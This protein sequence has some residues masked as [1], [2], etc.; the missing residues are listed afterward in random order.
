MKRF[1]GPPTGCRD[2]VALGY[3]LNGYYL[4][5]GVKKNNSNKTEMQTVYCQFKQ[6]QGNQLGGNKLLLI[7]QKL[8]LIIS[9]YIYRKTI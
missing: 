2:L 8:I 5:K 6:P 1:Y 7:F 4:V 3:T 9:K